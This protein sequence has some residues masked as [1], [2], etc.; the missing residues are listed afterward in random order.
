MSSI[1]GWGLRAYLLNCSVQVS[2]RLFF[3]HEGEDIIDARAVGLSRESYAKGLSQ[4]VHL[5][6]F[7]CQKIL[8]DRLQDCLIK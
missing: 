5:E 3:A 2:Q 6:P 7:S 8:E 1:P 4:L